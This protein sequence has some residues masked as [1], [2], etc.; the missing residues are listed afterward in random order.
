MET[1][2]LDADWIK[3]GK[4]MGVDFNAIPVEEWVKGCDH[5]LEH[6]QTVNG[7]PSLIAS[8]AWDHLKEDA[9]YYV[10]LDKMENAG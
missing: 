8:I 9:Q 6:W 3:L 10:K 5:E 2:T 7:K 4:L 1:A